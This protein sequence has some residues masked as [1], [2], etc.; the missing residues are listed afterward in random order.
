MKV[1][2]AQY[3]KSSRTLGNISI[4]V[5]RLHRT[6]QAKELR[7]VTGGGLLDVGIHCE[8]W[9]Q[10]AADRPSLACS[11]VEP[12]EAEAGWCSTRLV[13]SCG[14][15]SCECYPPESRGASSRLVPMCSLISV[16]LRTTCGVHQLSRYGSQRYHPPDVV[17]AA[18]SLALCI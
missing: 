1:G 15:A 11:P 16:L 3:V 13:C 17:R 2:R 8:D 18:V 12:V 6:C 5:G 14:H 9:G 4:S 7:M 10:V